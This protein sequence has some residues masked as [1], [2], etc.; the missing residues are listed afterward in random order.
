MIVFGISMA[1]QGIRLDGVSNSR[2]L[3]GYICQDGRKIKQN[4]LLRT[5]ELC[6][7]TI[8]GAKML[9]EQYGVK[10][11]I[12]FRMESERTGA[13]D[14]EVPGAKNTWISVMEMSDYGVEIQDVFR[15][16][17]EL[18]MDRTQAMLENAKA[19]FAAKMYDRILLTDRAKRGYL[20]FFRILLSQKDGAVLWHCSAGKDRAGL[21]SALLLYALGADGETIMADYMLSSESYREKAEFMAAFAGVNNLNEEAVQDAIA[22]VSVLPEYL[23]RAFEAITDE[24]GSVHS[25]LNKALGVSDKDIERL[26]DR[27]LEVC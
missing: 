11:I 13:V 21:A 22:M 15:A 4:T 18:K 17:V 16:A 14:R 3:G 1:T 25:Y 5:G 2:Q 10:N 23:N 27:F 19:G 7:L 9:A 12:D 8:D 20:Q 24:Y 6:G 26:R